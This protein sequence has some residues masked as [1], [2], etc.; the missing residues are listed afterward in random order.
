MILV[1][2]V[3]KFKE[4]F[5]RSST[6]HKTNLSKGKLKALEQVLSDR[7]ANYDD[8]PGVYVRSN[9]EKDLDLLW[10]VDR[11][12][13]KHRKMTRKQVIT[14]FVAGI[15]C[16]LFISSM[17]N[18]FSN[19]IADMDFWQVPVG[20]NVSPADNKAPM[21]STQQYIVKS[22]DT[23]DSIVMRFYGVYD[24]ERIKQIQAINN[25]EDASKIKLG[26]VLTIPIN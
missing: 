20:V 3:G 5:M 12:A 2:R 16:T 4:L 13:A 7:K 24:V 18:N 8:G 9:K 1:W 19:N 10:Q 25:L 14:S 21:V 11:V 22:G 23:I 6:F 15:L 26:Q 17:V